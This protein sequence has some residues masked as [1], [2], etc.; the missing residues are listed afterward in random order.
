MAYRI[1]PAMRSTEFSAY[2]LVFGRE[3]LTPID[4]ELIPP[5]DVPNSNAQ[6]L[7]Q[8]IDNLRLATTL[9]KETVKLN[10]E[11][12]R[13]T[14]DATAKDN[15]FKIGQTVLVC[16]PHAQK[17]LSSKLQIKW[18]GPYYIVECCQNH[19]YSLRHANSHVLMKTVAHANWLNPF[20][21]DVNAQRGDT[22]DDGDDSEEADNPED[23]IN[24]Q[25][26]SDANDHVITRQVDHRNDNN[27]QA[28]QSQDEHAQN[29]IER[30]LRS[31]RYKGKL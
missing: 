28:D 18:Q 2:I 29:K 27:V 24:K 17:G 1:I 4:T 26:D 30:V 22:V 21:E 16:T 19:I 3:M 8:I 12:N 31:K 9:A 6:H 7:K 11:R 5:E 25:S 23:R 15:N 10:I 13:K 14:Y 20:N